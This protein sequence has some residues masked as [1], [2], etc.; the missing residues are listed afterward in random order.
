[1]TLLGGAEVANGT[2]R[3]VERDLFPVLGARPLLGRVFEAGDFDDANPRGVLLSHRLRMEQ[4]N[5]DR[6]VPGGRVM[7]DN[8]SCSV[9]GVMPEEFQ[10]PTSFFSMWIAD[11]EKVT[12]PLKT[13]RNII[14][15]LKRL[16]DS[17]N[18]Q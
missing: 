1:M 16:S 7:L 11:R 5:G 13:Q 9:I 14:V 12:D 18:E 15:R 8:E 6:T 10:F 2:A 17:L 3:I 4:F